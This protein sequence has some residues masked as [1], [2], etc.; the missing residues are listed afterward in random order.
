MLT[1][2]D[3]LEIVAETDA[4]TGA[5]AVSGSG[6]GIAISP[7]VGLTLST[8]T[9]GAPPRHRRDARRAR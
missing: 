6:G 1:A 9:T 5:E 4:E 3:S 2:L 8:V 7:S